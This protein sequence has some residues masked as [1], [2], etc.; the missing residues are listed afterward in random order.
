ME[1]FGMGCEA[2][3]SGDPNR[4]GDDTS[5]KEL[6]NDIAKLKQGGLSGFEGPKDRGAPSLLAAVVAA[7]KGDKKACEPLLKPLQ[8]RC[9]EA[10]N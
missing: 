10:V 9:G 7:A 2:I 8:S 4:C 1:P 6:V 3:V 5:C